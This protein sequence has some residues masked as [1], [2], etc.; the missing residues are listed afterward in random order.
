MAIDFGLFELAGPFASGVDGVAEL[1]K[2]AGLEGGGGHLGWFSA[3]PSSKLRV[4]VVRHPCDWLAHF[5]CEGNLQLHNFFAG[6]VHT[7]DGFVEGYLDKRSGEI[8]SV[9]DDY[10]CDTRFRLE[11]M[12]WALAELLESLG[13][14]EST[15]QKITQRE[16]SIPK[17]SV[18]W[19]PVLRLRV[20]VAEREMCSTFD[21]W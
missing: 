13:V 9:F 8:L 16:F 6:R 21:Y 20:L 5:Y 1:C 3:E 18:R 12:P 19:N 4:S 11:D 7:F 17:A 14:P 15:W 10:K 2:S